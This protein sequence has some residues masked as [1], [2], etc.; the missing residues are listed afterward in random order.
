MDKMSIPQSDISDILESW[1]IHC[2][3]VNGLIMYVCVYVCVCVC[4]CVFVYVY[5]LGILVIKLVYKKNN[6]DGCFITFQLW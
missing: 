5:C 6:T 1:Q 3:H 4:V 2:L